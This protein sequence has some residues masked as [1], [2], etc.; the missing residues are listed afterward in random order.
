MSGEGFARRRREAGEVTSG[1]ERRRRYLYRDEYTYPNRRRAFFTQTIVLLQMY[2]ITRVVVL[3]LV[4]VFV[5]ILVVPVVL[6][7]ARCTSGV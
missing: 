4:I 1:D 5:A 2:P 7:V 3:A 6:V